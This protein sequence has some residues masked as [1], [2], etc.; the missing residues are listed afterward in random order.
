MNYGRII[1][2]GIIFSIVFIL[3]TPTV[4]SSE[5]N[6]DINYQYN[7]FNARKF[8]QNIDISSLL[9]ATLYTTCGEIHKTNQIIFGLY[10]DIDVDGNDDT[11]IDG[12]DIRIQYILL[13]WFSMGDSLSFGVNFVINIE[14]LCNEIKD[15][16]FTA[17]IKLDNVEIGFRSPI[18]SINEI[19][20]KLQLSSLIFLRLLDSTY[21]FTFSTNPYYSSTV[22]ENMLVFFVSYNDSSDK[23]EYMFSFEPTVATEITISSTKDP[24]MWKYSFKRNPE[25]GTTLIAHITKEEI[26]DIKDTI[27]T[28]RN[29]PKEISFAFSITPFKRDGGK[30][31]YQSENTYS[32]ELQIESNKLGICRYATIKNPPKEIY[33]EWIPTKNNGYLKLITNSTGTSLTLQDKLVNP[34]VN[35]SLENIGN[36]DFISH[37]N[38]TNPGTL[39]VIR[40]SSVNLVIHAFIE[41]WETKINTSLLHN[42]NIKWD[43]NKTGYIFCDTNWKSIKTV[44]ILIKAQSIGVKI[45]ADTFKAEDFQ[46][47][48]DEEWN[49]TSIGTIDFLSISI[50]LYLNDVW[51]HIWPW[52]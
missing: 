41:E 35:I 34:T 11:G 17:K 38:L 9:Q 21:G 37:W 42:L 24:R 25:R 49:R 31:I 27:V 26:S 12:K 3:I 7:S 46:L 28:I 14:R 39:R 8:M 32:T 33:A 6:M 19:P 40:N 48:W 5:K 43:V 10:N 45:K 52:I 1:W 44:D 18:A 29:L 30:I 22:N 36:T 2:R 16:D 15:K 23:Q 47:N 51:Y 4:L 13:P 50:D 20:K